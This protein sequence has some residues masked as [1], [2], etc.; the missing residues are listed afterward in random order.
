MVFVCFLLK[1]GR[2]PL[3]HALIITELSVMSSLL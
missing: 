1:T 2:D 3:L